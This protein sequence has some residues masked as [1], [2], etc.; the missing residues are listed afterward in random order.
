MEIA[1]CCSGKK[2][3]GMV[4]DFPSTIWRQMV[5]PHLKFLGLLMTNFPDNI[6]RQTKTE[7]K[8]QLLEIVAE[9]QRSILI[10]RVSGL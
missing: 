8:K 1:R 4:F 10:W 7:D 6:F 9:Y 3:Y 5:Q 2:H